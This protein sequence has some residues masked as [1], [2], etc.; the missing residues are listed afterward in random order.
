MSRRVD[1]DNDMALRG[2]APATGQAGL[3]AN[4]SGKTGH[5]YLWL[6][7]TRSIGIPGENNYAQSST[8][9]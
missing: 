9:T 8:G 4:K 6:V 5:Y 1:Q 3:L 7:C 2:L